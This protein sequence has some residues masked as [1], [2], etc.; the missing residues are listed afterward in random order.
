MEF[1]AGY[2]FSAAPA[3]AGCSNP[4]ATTKR[5][6]RSTETE[7]V[8]TVSGETLR[9]A[10]DMSL[11]VDQVTPHFRLIDWVYYCRVARRHVF[12]INI[13]E[14]WTSENTSQGNS[15]SAHIGVNLNDKAADSDDVEAQEVPAPMGRD[16]AKKKGSSSGARSETSIA[17]DPSL[18]DALL[19]KFTMAAT[20]FF[21]QRKESSSEYLRI[22]ERELKLEE[23]KCQENYS[24]TEQV[25]SIQQLL[26]YCLIIGTE[27]DI[28]EIIYSDHMT[29]L[30][31]K[32]RDKNFGF[33]HGILSNSNFTKDPYKLTNIELTAHMIDVNNQKDSVSPLP[34]A[35]KPK[36]G[37]Y[38]TV[39]PTLPKSQGLEVLGALSK[40][41]VKN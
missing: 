34:L 17:G 37:K 39:T 25:N 12:G 3:V 33:L 5:S 11:K 31:N 40:K 6:K 23:R 35:A 1:E 24:F 27:V 13:F 38:Q 10:G 15:D 14:S 4:T 28:G 29:K 2:S 30:L 32:S 18:V 22:K 7:V 36:K 16:R 19:S 26:A 21:T 20:P 8:V 41:S 9:E